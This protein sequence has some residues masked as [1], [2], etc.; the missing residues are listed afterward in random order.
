MKLFNIESGHDSFH[1]WIG[2]FGV[3]VCWP[4]LWKSRPDYCR[5]WREPVDE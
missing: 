4:D 5:R 2:P 3:H 1:F